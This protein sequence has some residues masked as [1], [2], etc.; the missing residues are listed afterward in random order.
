MLKY[1]NG[2]KQL[3]C[4]NRFTAG[5]DLIAV[6][7][8]GVT[9]LNIGDHIISEAIAL[10][11][12]DL[13]PQK[14]VVPFSSHAGFRKNARNLFNSCRLRFWGGANMLDHY[15]LPF[16]NYSPDIPLS[17]SLFF[18]PSLLLGVGNGSA[19]DKPFNVFARFFYKRM[20]SRNGIH[21]VRDRNTLESLHKLGFDNVVCT[22]CPTT[23]RLTP[24]KCGRIPGAR[25]SEVIFT[26]TDYR[27]EPEAD[28]RFVQ[29]L[30]ECYSRLHFFPQGAGDIDYLRGLGLM[31][32]RIT[33]ITPVLSRY[34][35]ML[36]PGKVDY[37]GTRLHGGIRAMQKG[38]RALIIGIDNRAAD[39]H[40]DINLPMVVRGDVAGIKN[41]ICNPEPCS[42][43]I[44][45]DAIESWKRQF[46]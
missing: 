43:K 45:F 16:N 35:A 24:E 36:C 12:H 11:L 33:C 29:L 44:D 1:W 21:S 41:W 25:A 42:L 3:C 28:R 19:A 5:E 9:T 22:G 23:W 38:C 10:E 26:L 37:V 46:R 34:D 17:E 20:L 31:D 30:K 2:V 6:I 40:H 27:T 15:L 13:F 18:E 14:F 39:I 4:G 32:D 8:P 7:S